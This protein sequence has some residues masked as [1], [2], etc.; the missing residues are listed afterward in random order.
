MT[1]TC[2][3][4]GST[5]EGPGDRRMIAS[6]WSKWNGTLAGYW[7]M[8][9]ERRKDYCPPCSESRWREEVKGEA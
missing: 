9:T 1:C 7:W 6:A 4:C 3:D 8:Q 5:F 2:H